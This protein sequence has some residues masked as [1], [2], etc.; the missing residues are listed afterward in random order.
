MFASL[1]EYTGLRKVWN[2]SMYNAKGLSKKQKY[3]KTKIYE[4]TDLKGLKEALEKIEKARYLENID[5][6]EQNG[7]RNYRATRRER[8]LSDR[9]DMV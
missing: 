8:Q 6:H 1:V 3:I 4:R 9:Q 7:T 2:D 5:K